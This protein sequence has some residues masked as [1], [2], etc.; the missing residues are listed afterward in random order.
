M[1]VECHVAVVEAAEDIA[2]RGFVV[3]LVHSEI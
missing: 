3:F 1:A 2:N